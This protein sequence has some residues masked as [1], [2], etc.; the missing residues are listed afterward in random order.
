MPAAAVVVAWLWF[1]G[2]AC[3]R[4]EAVDRPPNVIVVLMDDLG[5]AD[6]GCYGST[7]HRTPRLD[8][9]AATGTRFTQAYA[10]CPVCSPTRAALLTG[11]WPARLRITDW[12]PGRPDGPDQRLRHA[13]FLQQL[14]LEEVTLAERLRAA[15]FATA[16]VG[17]W[18]LGGEGFEPTR[19]GFDLNIAGDRRGVPLDYFSPYRRDGRTMPGLERAPPEEYL[20]DRLTDEA[21]AFVERNRERPFFLYLSHFAVHVPLR[22]PK[23]LVGNYPAVE[24]FHGRQN[25]PVYAAMLEGVDTGFGRLLDRLRDWSL[26][27][28]TIIVFTSDNGGQAITEGP[29]AP[30]TSNAPLRDGKGFL[31]EG[32]IRVPLVIAGPGVRSG[33]VSAFPTSTIDLVPTLL[34][35]CRVADDRSHDGVSLAPTLAGREQ[36]ERPPLYWHYP[37]YANHAS[38]PGGAI[39]VRD[40]K[41]IE[42]YDTGRRELFDVETD[43]GEKRNLAE[44]E[45]ERVRELAGKLDAWR[46]GVNARMPTPNPDYHPNRQDE[47]GFVVMPARHADVHGA[48]L[49]FEPM[50]HKNTLGYWVRAE[51]W[52]EW[53]FEITTPGRFDLEVSQGCGEGSGGAEVI[54][55]V[56]GQSIGMIVQETG[57]FQDF[58][59][60]RI[61]TITLE[62][63][64]RYTLTVTPKTKPGPAVMDVRQVRLIPR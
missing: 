34:E 15:G 26:D 4:D 21:I 16:S 31:Y 47:Q 60:R 6:L 37:H 59:P 25:N 10:A 27:G 55:E 39:R 13:E 35:L 30:P 24:A 2:L 51:D 40:H 14:P 61:G 64:G 38:R 52:A 41:L 45:P 56:G 12:I 1:P 18:H 50:P 36:V 9:W 28:R 7:W 32:G 11:K 17:K 62:R 5:W 48:M 49:R 29:N 42:F 44:Q 8:R 53:Q 43:P 3:A 33:H 54:W 20:T 58:L 22:A 46:R 63:P 57:G 23:S 19:Q